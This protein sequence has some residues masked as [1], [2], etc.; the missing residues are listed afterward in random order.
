MPEQITDLEK[1]LELFTKWLRG[2]G[3]KVSESKL[4]VCL[5]H[6]FDQPLINAK[7]FL[8]KVSSKKTQ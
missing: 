2:T 4:E 6:R 5:F 8:T 3:L 1:S 7:G